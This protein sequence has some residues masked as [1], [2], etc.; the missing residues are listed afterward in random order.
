MSDYYYFKIL[1]LNISEYIVYFEK[2][3]LDMKIVK[4]CLMIKNNQQIILNVVKKNQ[5]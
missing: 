3:I 4:L 1:Y 2:K 5:R